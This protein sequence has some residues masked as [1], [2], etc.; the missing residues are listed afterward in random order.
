MVYFVKMALK[1]SAF[2]RRQE[3]WQGTY[4]FRCGVIATNSGKFEAAWD[5]DLTSHGASMSLSCPPPLQFTAC[6]G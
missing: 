2:L 4:Y 5:I 6:M 3:V 1:Q